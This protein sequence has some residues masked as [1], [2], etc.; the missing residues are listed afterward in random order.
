M[1]SEAL[2]AGFVYDLTTYCSLEGQASANRRRWYIS[3]ITLPAPTI[4]DLVSWIDGQQAADYKALICT[5]AIYNGVVGTRNKLYGLAPFPA[6]VVSAANVGPG[7]AGATPLPKQAAGV[8]SLYTPFQGPRSRGRMYIPFPS[9]SD[10]TTSGVPTASYVTNMRTFAVNFVIAQN[11]TGVAGGT[12]TALACLVDK[13]PPLRNPFI[14]TFIARDKWGTQRRRG[15]F[16]RLNASP[17]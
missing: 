3:A 12:A 17:V 8:L 16:G 4:Q 11:F 14:T 1:A 7:T 10:T 15:D 13:G 2:A 6:D 9:A 5:P